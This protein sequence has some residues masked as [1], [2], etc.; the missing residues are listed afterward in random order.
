[1]EMQ[2]THGQQRT[3]MQRLKPILFALMGK[4]GL[5]SSE[6]Y[7]LVN[8]IAIRF[9][10]PTVAETADIACMNRCIQAGNPLKDKAVQRL[11]D[12]EEC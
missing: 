12:D 5:V 6:N 1:M 4:A 8:Y 7:L 3:P 9:A 10:V 11:F 2:R